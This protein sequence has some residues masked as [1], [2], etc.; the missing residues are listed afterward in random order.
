MINR[1]KQY[2][3]KNLNITLIIAV[4]TLCLIS[5][6]AVRMAGGDEDGLHYMKSQLVG[7]AMGIFVIAFLA[8]LD[9]HFIC[10]FTILYY[11]FGLALTAATHSPLGSCGSTDSYRWV[12]LG[13][14]SLQ[15]SELMKVIFILTLS[16]L[17]VQLEKRLDRFSTL[18][19]VAIITVIPILLIMTQPDLSSSLV[20]LFIM[21]IMVFAA[22]VSYKLLVPILVIGIPI[23]VVM[24]WYIQQPYNVLLHGYQ[25]NRII[26]W[27]HPDNDP[28]QLNYQQN[29]S[30]AAIA[31]G[32]LYGKFLQDGGT[33]GMSRAYSGLA[34][35]ESDF[36]WCVIGEEFGFLGCLVILL[37]LGTII[38]KCFMVARKAKDFLGMLIAV[39]V[40]SM[41]MFQIFCNICVATRMFPNTG[42][43]LPFLSNGLSSMM[44]SMIG[45]GLVTNVGIQPA[46]SSKGG[47]TMRTAYAS[48]TD[49]DIDIDFDL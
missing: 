39:G 43:P 27:L 37:L 48:D 47:F 28:L 34:V 30:I 10:Q 13:G 19:I 8:V 41:F 14:F 45:I 25:Y 9:Y 46:K 24:F 12:K 7:M 32:G 1:I 31:E 16:A 15:P 38:F 6:F 35:N 11:L 21:M 23:S 18:I 40:A 4:I 36:I 22:G 26:A 17:F 42:L 44:A 2:D 29:R 49:R 5:S 3:W 33:H 20:I